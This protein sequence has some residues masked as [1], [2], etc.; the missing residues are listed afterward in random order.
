LVNGYAACRVRPTAST[1][2]TPDLRRDISNGNRSCIYCRHLHKARF[3]RLL[4]STPSSTDRSLLLAHRPG[5]CTTLSV[6]HVS[7][8]VIAMPQACTHSHALSE[9]A[10]HRP[11][12]TASSSRQHR[13][14]SLADDLIPP[15]N[16]NGLDPRS[17][18]NATS[19]ALLGDSVWEVCKL[20]LHLSM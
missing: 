5:L 13:P 6:S 16:M 10:G 20:F 19:L 4:I 1:W 15:P 8:P 3:H 18:W 2:A 17:R 11:R 14:Q 9:R 7:W 12:W